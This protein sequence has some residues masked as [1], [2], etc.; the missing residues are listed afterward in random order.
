LVSAVVHAERAHWG[1]DNQLRWVLDVTFREDDSR[2]RHDHAPANFNTLRRLALN[3]LRRHPAATSVKQKRWK[4]ALD[5]EFRS[6]IVFGRCFSFG[7][8]GTKRSAHEDLL[9]RFANW[10]FLSVAFL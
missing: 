9:R 4:A 7:T 1:I 5:D 10:T 2:I 6:N 8:P 3:L